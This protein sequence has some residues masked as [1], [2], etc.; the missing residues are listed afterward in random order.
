MNAEGLLP[1]LSWAI[2]A[3]WGLG[4]LLLAALSLNPS[5]RERIKPL[6]YLMASELVIIGIGVAPWHL[7]G[8]LLGLLMVAGAARIGYEAGHEIGRAHV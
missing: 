8:G 5:W 4:C 2:L 3:A 7:P 6:W 1:T